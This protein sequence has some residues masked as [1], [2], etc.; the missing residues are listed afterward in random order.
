MESA[1]CE[2]ENDNFSGMD[3]IDKTSIKEWMN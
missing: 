1:N 2:T 3:L